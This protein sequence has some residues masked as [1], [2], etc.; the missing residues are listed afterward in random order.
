MGD[1]GDLSLRLSRTRRNALKMGGIVATAVVA[2]LAS[3]KGVIAAPGGIPGPPPGRPGRGPPIKCMLK[4]AAIATATGRRQIEELAIGDIVPTMYGGMRPI[5][6]IGRYVLKRIDRSKAWPKSV[7]PIQIVR[8]AIAA[9]IPERDLFL[10]SEH[11]LL[12]D[13]V[14]VTVGSLVNDVTIKR[15]EAREDDELKYFHIKVEGHDVIYAEG[16]AVET[17]VTADESFDNFNEY[18]SLYG[19]PYEAARCA[20]LLSCTGGARELRSRARSALAPWIER[21]QEV[22]RIRDRLEDRALSERLELA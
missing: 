6:W 18:L 16:A 9:D 7:Q 22:D 10:S 8:S 19:E 20:P 1:M 14:L 4:G 15:F 3:S 21:R 5:E 13:G 17:M 2:A 11:A 12:V